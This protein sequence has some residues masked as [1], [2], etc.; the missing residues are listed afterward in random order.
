[1]RSMFLLDPNLERQ[2]QKSRLPHII[3]SRYCAH[4]SIAEADR[5]VDVLDNEE[6]VISEKCLDKPS[7]KDFSETSSSHSG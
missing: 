3:P 7:A 5:I 4:K 2:V 1:M 6:G